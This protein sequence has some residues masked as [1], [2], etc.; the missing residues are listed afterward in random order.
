MKFP[1]VARPTAFVCCAVPMHK[2]PLLSLSLLAKANPNKQTKQSLDSTT[3]D[4]KLTLIVSKATMAMDWLARVPLN[5][6]PEILYQQHREESGEYVYELPPDCSVKGLIKGKK[7]G[8]SDDLRQERI[9]FGRKY[10]LLA[11]ILFE[12]TFDEWFANSNATLNDLVSIDEACLA[13]FETMV[14]FFTQSTSFFAGKLEAKVAELVRFTGLTKKFISPHYKPLGKLKTDMDFHSFL[15]DYLRSED[16]KN[17]VDGN[18]YNEDTLHAMIHIIRTSIRDESVERQFFQMYLNSLKEVPRNVKWDIGHLTSLSKHC[19]K[20]FYDD[21]A[22]SIMLRINERCLN[23]FGRH[24][25]SRPSSKHPNQKYSIDVLSTKIKGYLNF[26]DEEC[27]QYWISF[28]LSRTQPQQ[29]KNEKL[30]NYHAHKLARLIQDGI[31]S[32]ADIIELLQCREYTFNQTVALSKPFLKMMT[33]FLSFYHAAR[34]IPVMNSYPGVLAKDATFSLPT[35]KELQTL[36][37]QQAPKEKKYAKNNNSQ[38]QSMQPMHHHSYPTSYGYPGHY[39]PLMVQGHGAI[40][41]AFQNWNDSGICGERTHNSAYAPAKKAFLKKADFQAESQRQEEM[42]SDE[43]TEELKEPEDLDA[44]VK[45]CQEDAISF[46][47]SRKE[48]LENPQSLKA[49]D[50][51]EKPKE[52]AVG[53]VAAASH[54]AAKVSIIASKATDP[55]RGLKDVSNSAVTTMAGSIGKAVVSTVAAASHKAA[56]VSIIASKATDPKR[57]EENASNRRKP[58]VCTLLSDSWYT[59]TFQSKP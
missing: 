14:S 49:T 19:L 7:G 51:I 40:T 48:A 3:S 36:F 53:T 13:A 42:N 29:A 50:S 25:S 33:T 5:L 1:V 21:A 45:L 46:M 30:A 8:S 57:G 28:G 24:F 17:Q 44:V 41:Q 55:K 2:R 9:K 59:H 27:E 20:D 52:A 22:D 31:Y 23:N 43:K 26:R 37:D 54:K 34:K 4:F 58:S 6:H 47:D 32:L 12:H 39:S 10:L 11:Y 15:D 56:K 38:H 35:T 18:R 16:L